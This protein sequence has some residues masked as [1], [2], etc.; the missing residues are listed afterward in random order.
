MR[1]IEFL[2]RLLRNSISVRNRRE[3]SD[4]ASYYNWWLQVASVWCL[5]A[6]LSA[7]EEEAMKLSTKR[8]LCRSGN[9]RSGPQLR[10]TVQA[11]AGAAF[12]NCRVRRYSLSYLEQLFAKLSPRRLVV[13][14]RG[15]GGGYRLAQSAQG[16]RVSRTSSWQWTSPIK[17][18]RCKPKSAKGCLGRSGRCQTHDLWEEL[19]PSNRGVSEIGNAWPMCSSAGVGIGRG[20][21]APRTTRPRAAA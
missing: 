8:A 11:T 4:E 3:E 21:Q 13:A 7:S 6:S 10:A 16:T 20:R 15:P 2:T 19:W 17:A 9:G 18:T 1:A 5:T 12:R 14:A